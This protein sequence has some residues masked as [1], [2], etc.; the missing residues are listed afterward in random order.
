M[1][2]TKNILNC[3]VFLLLCDLIQCQNKKFDECFVTT[4][5]FSALFKSNSQ[6]F[7]LDYK[8]VGFF[9]FRKYSFANFFAK[10]WGTS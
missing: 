9:K 4:R 8:R 3:V 6:T 2:Y 7:Y 1:I 10:K 5:K